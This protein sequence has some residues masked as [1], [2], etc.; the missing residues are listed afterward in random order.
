MKEGPLKTVG[1]IALRNLARHR[2]KTVITTIAVAVS[3]A[4]YI[5][6]DAWLLG[7]NLDSRRNIVSYEIG[8]AK[9]QSDAYFAKKDEL[10]MY[11]SFVGWE[12]IADALETAGY[13]SAPRFVFSGTLYSRTGT[14]PIL[15]DAVD[16]EQ[17]TAL[18]RYPDFVESG[19][20]PEAGRAEL[21]LGTVAA[22]KLRVGIPRRPTT[23]EYEK[24]VYGAATDAGEAG[25]IAGLYDERDGLMALRDDAGAAELDRLWGILSRSGRMD[26]RISTV[27]DMVAAPETVRRD[28]FEEDLL[29]SLDAEGRALA[30]GSYE[31]D[32]VLDEYY[33]TTDD[34]A[35]LAA[36]LRAMT[37]ADY[38]GAIR[39]VNQLIDATVVG[40]VNS[41]NP[42]TNGNVGFIPLDALQGEAGLMLDGAVTELLIRSSGASDTALPGKAERPESIRAALDSALAASGET[43]PEGLSVRGWEAYA[44]DYLAASAGDNVSTRVMIVFLFILSFIG[45]ANTMLMAVLERTKEIGMMRALGMTDGQL[46]LSYSIEAGMIGFLGSMAG[47][48]LGCLI[49][50]PMVEYGVD[51]SSMSKEMGGDFGY[52]VAA[53]FRSAW[54]PATIILTA[55]AATLLSALM[56]LPPTIRALRLPVTESLRFE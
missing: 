43:L 45:I 55:A 35:T 12:K 21:A 26:V 46:L 19:R 34:P 38:S 51:F 15:F 49:N 33:L 32:P 56:A 6:A 3:V 37:V 53:L 39:H 54:N 23:E 10:P 7:M 5:A 41:P 25:F 50:I 17:E 16:P 27:I 42:K 36:L 30:L 18:L 14:A 47:V 1:T 48:A 29:P 2:V 9:I 13:D 11:E 24:D 52:R 22:D 28:R 40:I 4:L 20:F 31:R 44:E 8:A